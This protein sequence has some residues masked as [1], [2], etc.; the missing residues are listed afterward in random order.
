MGPSQRATCRVHRILMQC[1]PASPDKI[2]HKRS[3][4]LICMI[5]RDACRSTSSLSP[6]V[7]ITH[8]Q[9]IYRRGSR[10]APT[11]DN[12]FDTT[13]TNIYSRSALDLHL[14]AI[15]GTAPMD[16]RHIWR[17][18]RGTSLGRTFGD[19]KELP[20]LAEVCALIASSEVRGRGRSLLSL[21][22]A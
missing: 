4:T 5:H 18:S 6:T 12:L 20:G 14:G 1:M 8:L 22:L 16:A 13:S 3:N 9:G 11:V 15:Q 7:H 17:P 10:T 21:G 19:P 2:H